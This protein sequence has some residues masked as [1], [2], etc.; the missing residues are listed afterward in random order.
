MADAIEWAWAVAGADVL[1][2]SWSYQIGLV[3]PEVEAA[4]SDALTYGRGGK[5]CVIVFCSGNDDAIL[6]LMR[7][8]TII[9][10]RFTNL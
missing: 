5:G 6:K 1:S 2:N 10:Y 8:T 4:I 9:Q 7:P 3:L